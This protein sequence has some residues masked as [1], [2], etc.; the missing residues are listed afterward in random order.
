VRRTCEYHE[1][2]ATLNDPD[3]A[4]REP[5]VDFVELATSSSEIPPPP[6]EQMWL[7]AKHYDGWQCMLA[8]VR[9][10]QEDYDW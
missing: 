4:C 1:K 7:C 2:F 5:A 10:L 8:H 3:L 9:S 6:P